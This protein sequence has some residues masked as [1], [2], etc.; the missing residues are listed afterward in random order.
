MSA[1][2]APLDAPAVVTIDLHRGH[3]DPAVATLPLEPAA[4]WDLVARVVPALDAFRARGVPIVHVVTAYR[5]RGEILSNPY[6]AAQVDRAGSSRA[7]IADHNLAPGPGLELMPGIMGEGDIVVA[8]KKRYDCF[9]GTDLDLV[10]RS[11]GAR[12]LLVAGVNT[13][14]CV[15]ATAVAASVR[16]Y[17]VVVLEDAVASMMG[18]GPHRDALGILA[19]SFGWVA[20]SAE[21]LALVDRGRPAAV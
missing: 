16:D 17:A 8:T 4:A 21:A 13:N 5:T 6:W 18:E 11:M 20:T 10:L 15:L 3:L 12:T 14:S 9:L 7:R 1:P 19:A 2:D